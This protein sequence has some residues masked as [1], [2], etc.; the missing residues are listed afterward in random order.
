METRA[1]S[2]ERQVWHHGAATPLNEQFTRFQ[3]QQSPDIRRVAGYQ[4]ARPGRW[5]RCQEAA[6]QVL[7]E[8]GGE[9]ERRRRRG[10]RER[11]K[12]RGGG[13]GEVWSYVAVHHSRVKEMDLSL[14]SLTLLTCGTQRG[15]HQEVIV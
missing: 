10:A 12:Q 2:S 8:G 7:D 13:G 1:P 5:A 9:S 4:A 15:V 14:S 11:G 6:R 3:H